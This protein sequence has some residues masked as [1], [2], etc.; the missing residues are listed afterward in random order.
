VRYFHAVL[1]FVK[2]LKKQATAVVEQEIKFLSWLART[3]QHGNVFEVSFINTLS[4]FS[5]GKFSL[6]RNSQLRKVKRTRKVLDFLRS[7]TLVVV[8]QQAQHSSPPSNHFWPNAGSYEGSCLAQLQQ[9]VSWE[10]G[11]CQ[12]N[13]QKSKSEST[14]FHPAT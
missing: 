3:L 11:G 5:V 7:A 10:I 2:T 9:L 1:S 14:S 12:R 4:M 6:K 8:F 13:L